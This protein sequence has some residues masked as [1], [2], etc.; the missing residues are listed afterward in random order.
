MLFI[1]SS[2]GSAKNLNRLKQIG[3]THIVNVAVAAGVGC[4]FPENFTYHKIDVEDLPTENIRQHF[5]E[6]LNFMRNAVEEGGKVKP[7][8]S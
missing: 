7:E 2:Q 8:N 1:F 3:I 6:A 4:Y 5:D